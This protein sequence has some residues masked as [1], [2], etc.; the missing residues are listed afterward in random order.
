M[1]L[2][3][4]AVIVGYTENEPVQ[5]GPIGQHSIAFHFLIFGQAVI[6]SQNETEL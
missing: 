2:P 6:G 1:S 4:K 3:V 5:N